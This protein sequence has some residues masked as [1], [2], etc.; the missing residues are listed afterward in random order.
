MIYNFYQHFKSDGSLQV[1]I[2]TVKRYTYPMKSDSNKTKIIYP[3]T[4]CKISIGNGDGLVLR[5]VPAKYSVKRKSS[6][7]ASKRQKRS[8]LK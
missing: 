5:P 8:G 2:T 7:K 4:E 6:G 1:D 3:V